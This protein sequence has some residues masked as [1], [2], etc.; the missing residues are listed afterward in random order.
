VLHLAAQAL[1]RRSYREPVATFETNV[2]GTV[3]LLEAVR[4]TPSVRAV[5]VVTSDKCY[6]NREREQAYVEGDPL[7]GADPYSAS[8]ACAE[9]V[10]GTWRQ[11]FLSG[12][13]VASARAGNVIGGGDWAADRLIPDCVAAL[14]AGRPIEI[15][16][17]R[18]TRPWQHVLDPVAGY[19][20]LAERLFASGGDYARAWNFG[21]ANHD[22]R[23]V[24][25]I[26]DAVIAGWG[27]GEWIGLDGPQPH[28]AGLLAVDASL[29]REKLGWAPRLRIDDALAWTIDW[30]RRQHLGESAEMLVRRQ[31]EQYE[32]LEAA[33]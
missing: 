3:N 17:P 33:V 29:A 1:V 13:A 22:V 19:L 24:S 21:P 15:R 28:E 18:A 8:K 10:T 11:S 16:N 32:T 14:I 6:E 7:G 25:A 31:I 2:M 12:I 23:P 30:Y 9:L 5:V 4:A 27:G 20:V 26:V